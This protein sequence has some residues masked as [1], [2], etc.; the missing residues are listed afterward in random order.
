M[1]TFC[2]KISKKY[3][4]SLFILSCLV[5]TSQGTST[6]GRSNCSSGA[7]FGPNCQFQCRCEQS[8]PGCDRETGQCPHACLSGWFGPACQYRIAKANL[9]PWA[10]DGN[11]ATCN[12]YQ[13]NLPPVILTTPAPLGWLVLGGK[14][15]DDLR[16]ID[17]KY[18]ENNSSTK[19][20]CPP[21]KAVTI[22]THSDSYYTREIFCGVTT[23]VN[24]VSIEGAGTIT[25]C[26][27]DISYGR[28][29]AV[30]QHV[31]YM[32][33]DGA[34]KASEATA[35]GGYASPS[36]ANQ[37]PAVSSAVDGVRWSSAISPCMPIS[38]RLDRTILSLV[39]D[40]TVV[41]STVY[42]YFDGSDC[43]A[44]ADSFLSVHARDEKFRKTDVALH[45]SK[46]Y[47]GK[48][49]V[50]SAPTTTMVY[51]LT[52]EN[53]KVTKN[54]SICE[55]EVYAECPTGMYGSR[56]EIPCNCED[57]GGCSPTGQCLGQC[58]PGFQGENCTM[59]CSGQNYGSDCLLS[60]SP[61]CKD[62][63]C[64]PT[65][66][67][68]TKG[69]DPGFKP[70]SCMALERTGAGSVKIIKEPET[71]RNE[72][73]GQSDKEIDELKDYIIW[74]AAGVGMLFLLLMSC[75]IY[76]AF[77]PSRSKGGDFKFITYDDVK[78]SE[79]RKKASWGSNICDA[80]D[81]EEMPQL[82]ATPSVLEAFM[83][84]PGQKRNET[85]L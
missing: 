10:T 12:T 15:E 61:F 17:I 68:C 64:S 14:S 57:K 16:Q 71:N 42:I 9:P 41:L 20:E 43:C 34:V 6:G 28:N 84:N 47:P 30:K 22:A 29:V 35:P 46:N 67:S 38:G 4:L 25:L 45:A 24:M 65:I 23:T 54:L 13:T 55:I 21:V 79:L 60:C 19:R 75:N 33:A 27:I 26:S 50:Y 3:I 83:N 49:L 52:I 72:T 36:A 69:C 85:Y 56:C 53:Q 2:D 48:Y 73:K 40:S 82:S 1:R 81:D 62:R 77:P 63:L 44:G 59:E 11:P 7:W 76:M 70:P 5:L 31:F 8:S 37:P 80:G 32:T 78:R 39:L 58:A 66:G 18:T 74:S 51:M